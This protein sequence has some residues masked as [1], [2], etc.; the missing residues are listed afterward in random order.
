MRLLCR[1]QQNFYICKKKSSSVVSEEGPGRVKQA[2]AGGELKMNALCKRYSAGVPRQAARCQCVTQHTIWTVA[3]TQQI[4]AKLFKL[5]Y[6]CCCLVQL[7]GIA[8]RSAT[9]HCPMKHWLPGWS[10]GPRWGMFKLAGMAN[11]QYSAASE[12]TRFVLFPPQ[13]Q[14]PTTISAAFT[15]RRSV[16]SGVALIH[17]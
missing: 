9:F 8:M 12:A 7:A 14:R 11:G 13:A 6:K 4:Q 10:S 2:R 16:A 5:L 17:K 3:F 15:S 1:R